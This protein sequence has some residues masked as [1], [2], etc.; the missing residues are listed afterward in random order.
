ML[1]QHIEFIPKSI[2]QKKLLLVNQLK[3]K[4]KSSQH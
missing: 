1:L 2:L 4:S 3:V